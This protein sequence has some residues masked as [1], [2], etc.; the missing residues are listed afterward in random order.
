MIKRNNDKPPS[1]TPSQIRRGEENKFWFRSDRFIV[2]DAQWYFITR[3][4]REVGPFC[5][6]KDVEHGLGL[7]VDSIEKRKTD[8]SSAINIAKKGEWAVTLFQ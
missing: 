8:V 5:G 3:E 7:F 2:V 1:D 6:R 4:D